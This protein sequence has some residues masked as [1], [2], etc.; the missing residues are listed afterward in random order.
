MGQGVDSIKGTNVQEAQKSERNVR[1]RN[2]GT[3]EPSN[4]AAREGQS[5]EDLEGR[6]KLKTA[7]VNCGF[8]VGFR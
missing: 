2:A 6:K 1:S 4:H 3:C 8:I 7:D 5:Q